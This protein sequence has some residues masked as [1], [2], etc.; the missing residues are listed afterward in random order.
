MKFHRFALSAVL[1]FICTAAFAQSDAQKAFE[2]LKAEAGTWDG[3]FEGKPIQVTL[4]VTSSG[5]LILHEMKQSNDPDDPV[6]AIYLD[7]DRLLMTHYCD[8]GNRPRF[9]GRLSP[10]GKTLEFDLLDVANLG[11]G[12]HGHMQHVVFTFGDTNHHSEDWTFAM[13]GVKTPGTGHF[14]LHR[15]N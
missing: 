3:M 4:R 10:D 1:L 14:D 5:N 12:Q 15:V 8:A 9:R 7:G 2:K 6:T 11:S 13:N